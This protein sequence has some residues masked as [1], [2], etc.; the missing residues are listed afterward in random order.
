MS[1][2]LEVDSDS[3]LPDL[4][5]LALIICSMKLAG[6]NMPGD[7]EKAPCRWGKGLGVMQEN[8]TDT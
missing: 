8:Q 7:N 4:G 6:K 5:L 3:M 2:P 1:F